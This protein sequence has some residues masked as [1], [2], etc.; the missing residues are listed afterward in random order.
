M[1]ITAR[2]EKRGTG[3]AHPLRV[4][5]TLAILLL[6]WTSPSFAAMRAMADG[7]LS[8]VV[9]QGF[10]SFTMSGGVANADF[11]GVSI[12]TY[13]EIDTLS[14]GYWDKGTGSGKGWD[15][16]WTQVKLG[17]TSN[18]LTFNGFYFQ[19]VFDPATVNDPA[20]RRLLSLT[21]GSKDVTGQL[22]ANFQSLSAIIGGKEVERGSLGVQSYQFNHTELSIDIELSGAR[23]GVWVNMGN[24][25]KL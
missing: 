7:E 2:G 9:G 18:D 4:A 17:T 11:S 8:A 6:M 20:N 22:T 12:S 1:K 21:M 19:A 15:Q 25:T 5:L 16:N 23:R 3:T 14:M 24:A 10:S 13:T